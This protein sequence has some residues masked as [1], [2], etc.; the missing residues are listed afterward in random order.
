MV[1][2]KVLQ[3]RELGFKVVGFIDDFPGVPRG[4]TFVIA[5]LALVVDALGAPERRP[6]VLFVRGP[7]DIGP[8]LRTAVGPEAVG[9][10]AVG[11][12]VVASRHDLL[13]GERAAPLV[14]A[15]GQG[16]GVALGAAA[17][18]AILAVV[19][20]VA[21]DAQRRARELAYL[22]TLGLSEG[23]AV[24]LTFVEHAPPAL[25][26][27]GIGVVLGLGLAWLLEPGLGLAAF[28][29]PG[30]PVHLQV[31]WTAV[32]AMG[33]SML[34]VVGI[35]VLANAWLARRLDPAQALRIGD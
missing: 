7:A 13:A 3:H 29:D 19:A 30:T 34:V 25:L 24:A 23:Q 10:E 8:A 27:L 15:V 16:F 17:A 33:L 12:G 1:A 18:Y 11:A 26:A 32:V 31:D 5:P 20:V 4:T 14:A 9:A 2:D 35:L 28:I 21:L 6:T 22:R